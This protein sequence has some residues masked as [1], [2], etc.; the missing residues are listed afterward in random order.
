VDLVRPFVA[1]RATAEGVDLE[2]LCA[3]DMVGFVLAS[4]RN[5]APS[6]AQLTVTALRSLLGFLH[7]DGL[8]ATPLAT[9][10]PSVANRRAG[11]PRFLE[12]DQV[13]AL[14]ASC[15][16]DSMAGRRDFA[17]LTLMVRLGCA[18]G[19]W[20]RC[21]WTT[22]TG[23]AARLSFAARAR[24]VTGCRCRSTSATPS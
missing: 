6:T 4:C 18:P 24:A 23:G 8:L 7:V 15:Y 16:R 10:V 3:G 17:M 1:G 22:S 14:L 5:R 20:P 13:K 19:R 11:L 21:G 12:P 9:V 2:Q